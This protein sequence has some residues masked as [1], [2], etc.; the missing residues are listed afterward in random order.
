MLSTE[1]IKLKNMIAD[2]ATEYR[3]ITTA[4]MWQMVNT[5]QRCAEN[6]EDL[7]AS[8]FKTRPELPLPAPVR[9]AHVLLSTI[10]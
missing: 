9:R 1:I 5:L 6:A 8:V 10:R 7:E 3:L 4:E 2:K